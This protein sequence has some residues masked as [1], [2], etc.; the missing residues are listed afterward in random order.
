MAAHIR[1]MHGSLPCS[2]NLISGRS[3]HTNT[4][5]ALPHYSLNIT[6][7]TFLPSKLRSSQLSRLLKFLSIKL[8]AHMHAACPTNHIPHFIARIIF[9]EEYKPRSSARL[10]GG[11][12]LFFILYVT[13]QNDM[14]VRICTV[15]WNWFCSGLPG[16]TSWS[17]GTEKQAGLVRSATHAWFHN[18]YTQKGK[19]QYETFSLY[20][21]SETDTGVWSGV[22]GPTQRRSGKRLKSG[23]KESGQICK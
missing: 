20:G 23:A 5:Y 2:K 1:D 12:F 4:L 22:L 7:H 13:I 10:G 9:R 11:G 21:T 18:A 3:V 8:L 6:F 17:R 15:N 14:K 16:L 19:L